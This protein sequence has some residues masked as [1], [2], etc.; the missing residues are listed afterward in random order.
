MR[1]QSVLIAWRKYLFQS[2]LRPGE[3]IPMPIHSRRRRF[4]ESFPQCMIEEASHEPQG[5][6]SSSIP[7]SASLVCTADRKRH[8]FQM[9]GHCLWCDASFPPAP[10]TAFMLCENC[11]HRSCM[12]VQRCFSCEWEKPFRPAHAALHH[13]GCGEVNVQPFSPIW[14]RSINPSHFQPISGILMSTKDCCFPSH[15]PFPDLFLR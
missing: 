12:H 6:K 1:E 7:T 9:L 15:P 4:S 10:A 11:S 14:Q 3:V 2:I 5:I 13:E 8:S